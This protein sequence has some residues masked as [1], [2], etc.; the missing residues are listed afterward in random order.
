MSL[1]PFL[2]LALIIGTLYLVIFLIWPDA[3]LIAIKKQELKASQDI[4]SGIKEKNVNITNLIASLNDSQN[5]NQKDFV[6]NYIPLE[7]REETIFNSLSRIAVSEG[8]ALGGVSL[9]IQKEEVPVA[10][11]P[12]VPQS[13]QGVIFGAGVGA[14]G[15]VIPASVL[16]GERKIKTTA[17][18]LGKY[19]NVKKF[20]EKVYV[21]DMLKSVSGVTLTSVKDDKGNPTENV[22]ANVVANFS[23]IAEAKINNDYSSPIFGKKS[24]NFA[25]VDQIKTLLSQKAEAV[26]VE[27]S[28]RS[29]PFLAN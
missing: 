7:K 15:V 11:A 1:K 9:D 3:Q 26:T 27:G 25:I 12:E 4:V 16:P 21:L 2:F 23:F 18:I 24:F 17:L 29:N 10:V 22:S 28:G 13:S 5:L 14:D 19:E 6:F 8:V 20:I